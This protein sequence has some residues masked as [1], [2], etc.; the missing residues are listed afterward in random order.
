MSLDLT[1]LPEDQLS[2]VHDLEGKTLKSGWKVLKKVKSKPG[3][4]GGNFSVCY[5][6]EKDG[7]HG[8]LKAINV[9]TFLNE[10][11]VDLPKAMAESLNTFNFEKEVLER[12]RSNNLSKVSKLLE[13]GSEN[14]D[15]YLIKNVHYLIFEKADSDVREHI[16][17][18]NEID[19]AWKLRSLHNISIGIKQLHNID[20]S[21]QDIKPS[22]IFV[23]NQ[24]LSKLGDLGRSLSGT[25]MGPHSSR[26]FAGD[27]RYAPPEVFHKY[28]LPDW[29]D[30]VFAIDCYL[31][32]SMASYYIVGHSMTALL[33]KNIN[34]NISILTL[35]FEQALSYW[36]TAFE[37]ALEALDNELIALHYEDKDLLLSTIRMLCYPDPRRRG[38]IKNI[39]GIGSNFSMERFIEIFN[40]LARKAEFRISK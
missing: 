11:E 20:I 23:F 16:N 12:C 28:V 37:D 21:H 19:F 40:R 9:L 8:F 35:S 38:H 29:K 39:K 15:G 25:I 36:I 34:G 17:Y 1:L 32:G 13:A 18:A 31:L 22:N 2:A 27:G 6:A 30:R 10:D 33:S 7:Q 3:S 4:S 26:N 5:L 14:I 24:K